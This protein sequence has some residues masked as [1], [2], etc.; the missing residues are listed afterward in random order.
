LDKPGKMPGFFHAFTF[1]TAFN[2]KMIFLGIQQTDEK[3][4]LKKMKIRY[5]N[6]RLPRN[7]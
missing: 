5:W 7:T 3:P 1:L 6:N 4:T 2:K